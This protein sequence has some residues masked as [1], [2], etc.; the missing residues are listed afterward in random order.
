MR[1]GVV[2]LFLLT[3]FG[4]AFAVPASAVVETTYLTFSGPVALHGVAM[5]A[6]EY[7]FRFPA[8]GVLQV[9]SKDRKIAYAMMFTIPK[10][11]TEVSWEHVVTFKET[12]K[13]APPAIE[14]WFRPGEST[15]FELLYS[16]PSN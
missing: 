13:D 12:R 14:T 6:G 7:I 9:L 15:G 8:P 10:T 16:K 3:L 1:R 5:P 2:I 11:R 4:V